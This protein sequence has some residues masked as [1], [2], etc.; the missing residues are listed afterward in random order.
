MSET[1]I[2]AIE[3]LEQQHHE[4]DA[5]FE[6]IESGSGNRRAL[7]A[8]VADALAVHA[9]IEEQIFYPMVKAS[10]TEDILLE[11]LEEHLGVKRVIADLL[12][13]GPE[14]ESFAAKIKVL[15]E[16]VQHHVKEERTDMFPKVRKLV[17]QARL[18]EIGA[19]MAGMTA[20]M[21]LTNPRLKV[22]SETSK[23]APL[24]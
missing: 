17:S 13:V 11:S 9:T 18:D 21:E 19:Q 5:L 4:V 16:L 1:R 14:D 22:P 7:F 24:P 20:E 2:G 6:K 3:L 12:D 15:K 23:P 8:K 10:S